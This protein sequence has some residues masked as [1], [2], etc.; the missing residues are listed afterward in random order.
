MSASALQSKIKALQKER[1]AAVEA[2]RERG[3]GARGV[4]KAALRER[5][6]VISTSFESK[7]LEES[8]GALGQQG[9]RAGREE[10]GAGEAAR[11]C[12]RAGQEGQGGGGD[13]LSKE[14]ERLGKTAE[15]ALKRSKALGGPKEKREKE[16][17]GYKAAMEEIERLKIQP[18]RAA[19]GVRA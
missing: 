9:R 10:G 3:V 5:V 14:M 13:R 19:E 17:A 1:E 11:S 4:K 15:E 18:R 8:F 6:K 2:M 7:G 16:I 12:H